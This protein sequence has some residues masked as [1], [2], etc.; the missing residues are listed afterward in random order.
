MKTKSFSR[1]IIETLQSKISLQINSKKG[2]KKSQILYLFGTRDITN[3][4][5]FY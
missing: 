5:K 2:T 3:L 1:K 4:L